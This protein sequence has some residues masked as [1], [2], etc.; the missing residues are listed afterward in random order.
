[1]GLGS[2]STVSLAEARQ[3]AQQCRQILLDGRDPIEQRK[4]EFDQR[5]IQTIRQVT[6]KECAESYIATHQ[7]AWRNPKHRAQWSSTLATYAFPVLGELTISVIDTPAVLKCLEP[8]WNRKPETA[9][10]LRGRIESVLDSA[11]ARGFRSSENPARWRGHLDKLL[12]APSK[13]RVVKHHSALPYVELPQFMSKLRSRDEIAARA[14]ELT[15]LTALR[16]SEV[17]GARWS[18]IDLASKVWIVPRERMKAGREHRVPLSKRALEVIGSSRGKQFVFPSSSDRP[19]SNMAMLKTLQRMGHGDITVHGFRS[20]FRDWAAE[21]TVHSNH[22]VE[23]AL[24]HIVGD[25]V[26]AAYRRGDL[27]LKR[28]RLMDEWARY[29]ERP[30]ASSAEIIVIYR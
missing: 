29:C 26:E 28:R 6:F 15:V 22:V 14:L 19:L 21:T 3:A 11:A 2:L 20:T 10:R 1:M 9:K 13:V 5:R 12:P 25:K 24:A 8:I 18:E 16:T 17:L 7:A 27:F 4:F 23:M 30:V